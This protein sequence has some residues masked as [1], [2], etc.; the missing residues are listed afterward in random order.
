M[1]WGAQRCVSVSVLHCYTQRARH[2]ER[3][4]AVNVLVR[5]LASVGR[6]EMLAAIFALVA[7]LV[8]CLNL[9][10]NV[11]CFFHN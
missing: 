8:P 10:K 11:Q 2:V 3:T 9:K 4:F 1:L 7:L 5:S 6:V